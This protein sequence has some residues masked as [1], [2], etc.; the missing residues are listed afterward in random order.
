MALNIQSGRSK[1]VEVLGLKELQQNVNEV[2]SAAVGKEAA[3]VA[4]GAGSV[5]LDRLA[6]NAKSV[7]V[8]HEVLDDLFM[9]TKRQPNLNGGQ[10]SVD[11]L[12][13][14]RKKGTRIP[15]DGYV[16]W[17]ASSQKG[18]N[19]FGL[20]NTRSR[21]KA[22]VKKAPD[23]RRIGEN[24]G[25]MWELGTTKMRA[26]PWFRTALQAVRSDVI[27]KMAAGYQG[28]VARHSK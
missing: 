2:M 11:V 20:L 19:S 23:G 12:V 1:S 13:G 28:I 16:T 17:R 25:T 21:G 7:G 18:L 14:L 3:D 10:G 15:A 9:Y 8:P 27:A 22:R 5:V 24:L 4:A 6:Y 26:R